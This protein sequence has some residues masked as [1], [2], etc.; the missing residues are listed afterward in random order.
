MTQGENGALGLHLSE[1]GVTVIFWVAE[2][3]VPRGDL[4]PSYAWP[5]A[6]YREFL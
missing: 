3:T 1:A 6:A 2:V 5:S 4:L